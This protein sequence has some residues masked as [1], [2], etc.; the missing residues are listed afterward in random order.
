M[1]TIIL[2]NAPINNGNRGCVALSYCSIYLIE[3]ILGQGNYRL[4]L[5][6]SEQAN[7]VHCISMAGKSYEYESIS[8]PNFYTFKG[9][10]KGLLSFNSSRHSI[11]VLR[12]A[13]TVFDIGQGD[14]F[15]DIYGKYRFDKI[16]FIHRVARFFNIPYVLLPQTIGPFKDASIYNK[17]KLSIEKAA[18]VMARDSTSFDFVK[19]KTTRSLNIDEY[20]DVAFFLPYNTIKYD[21]GYQKV[22]INISSLLWNGGYTKNNQ[23]GL[24]CDYKQFC[25]NIIDYFLRQ[26]RT[27]VYLIPHVVLQERGIENDYEVAYEL[28]REYEDPNLSIAPFAIGPVEIKSFIAGLD[29]FIGARMHATIASFSS[30]VPVIPLAYSRKFNG[31]FKETLSYPYVID[32]L[33]MSEETAL[34]DIIDAYNKR[35]KLKDIINDRLNGVVE[36]RK[37]E[38]LNDLKVYLTNHQN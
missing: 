14:S 12:H 13:N 37:E 6:N 31:L 35:N 1:R 36:E 21:E 38:L 3:K 2:A 20:I 15:A 26:T 16:D 28:W 8:I 10:V 5:T 33:T 29:F 25:R 27:K 9:I 7:G 32:M 17:A 22:G 30:G 24:S 23:F 34:A 11:S 19:T 18:L 4:Y